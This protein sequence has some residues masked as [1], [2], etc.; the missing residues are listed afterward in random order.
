MSDLWCFKNQAKIEWSFR[1]KGE[2]LCDGTC[3]GCTARKEDSQGSKW[4]R[5]EQAPGK[6]SEQIN[7]F[8]LELL[9][10][11]AGPVQEPQC[12]WS[13]DAL[14]FGRFISNFSDHYNRILFQSLHNNSHFLTCQK[15]NFRVDFSNFSQ[16]PGIMILWQSM[17]LHSCGQIISLFQPGRRC[18][19]DIQ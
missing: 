1:R 6:A 12:L 17:S 7:L 10:G 13:L 3:R 11:F 16:K 19:A 9:G 2:R 14:S 15:E 8:P 18:N 5:T 4:E